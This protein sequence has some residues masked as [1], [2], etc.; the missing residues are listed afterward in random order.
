MK[1]SIAS[2]LVL[3][4]VVGACGS[5]RRSEALQGALAIDDAGIGRG[6]VVFAQHCH[7]CHPGGEAGLGPA[8]NDKPLPEFLMR[9][10]VRHGLGVMP[11]FS[12]REISDADLQRLVDYL[13]A[14]RAQR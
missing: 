9:F 10:Q 11:A 7:K 14:R 6:R 2:V 13:K 5:A 3:P 12:E 1:L 8:L 4:L